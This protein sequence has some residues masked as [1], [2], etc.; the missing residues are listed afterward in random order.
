M[1]TIPLSLGNIILL[2]EKGGLS[3]SVPRQIDV[4]GPRGGERCRGSP[5]RRWVCGFQ[6]GDRGLEFSGM[7]KGQT[8]FFSPHSFMSCLCKTYFF[9]RSELLCNLFL[10]R[11]TLFKPKANNYTTKQH[12]FLK[13]M[14]FLQ[15][16]S[17]Q[18][19]SRV[20]LFATP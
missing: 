12:N 18:P 10:L 2:K 16:S 8:P 4:W 20:Q 3:E 9:L 17:I 19:L 7:R 11:L 13:G 15:F 5:R 14:F 6:R 1:K